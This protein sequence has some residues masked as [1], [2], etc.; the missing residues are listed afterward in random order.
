MHYEILLYKFLCF[1]LYKFEE[2]CLQPHVNWGFSWIFL[3]SDLAILLCEIRFGFFARTN[4]FK[5]CSVYFDYNRALVTVRH[6]SPHTVQL[7]RPTH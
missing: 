4:L 7:Q 2:V 1:F 5:N 3:L 6:R